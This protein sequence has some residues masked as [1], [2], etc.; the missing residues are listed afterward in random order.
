MY[1]A[2]LGRYP[3]SRMFYDDLIASVR[4]RKSEELTLDLQR[5]DIIIENL[6]FIY[7][8]CIASEGLLIDAAH[9][10]GDTELGKY[11]Q[12]HLA[13]EKGEIGIL[14]SDLGSEK[15]DPGTPDIYSMAM[16]GSQYYMIRHLSPVCLLGYLAV[17]EADPTPIGT[18]E[19]LEGLY[20]ANLFQFLRLHAIKDL[21]HCKEIETV[22]NQAPSSDHSLITFSAD[23]ALDHYGQAVMA[24]R[25]YHG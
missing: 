20:G 25:K 7:H 16:V 18:V 12:N 10:C 4:K 14:K 19:L 15:I 1:Q 11:Y 24:W 9:K 22:I 6:L 17:Q 3:L 23:N 21:E 2:Y 5:Y 8:A 13:E